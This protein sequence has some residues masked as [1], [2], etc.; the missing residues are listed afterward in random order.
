MRIASFDIGTRNMAYCVLEFIP[1]QPQYPIKVI[2]WNVLD[3]KYNN[4]ELKLCVE[5]TNQLDSYLNVFK[6]VDRLVIER[7]PDKRMMRISGIL[8]GYFATRFQVDHIGMLKKVDFFNA[9]NKFK[10]YTGPYV[11]KPGSLNGK[12]NYKNR[13][14]YATLLCRNMI[15]QFCSDRIDF[16]KK[17]TKNDDLSDCFLQGFTYIYN[18]FP[19]LKPTFSGCYTSQPVQKEEKRI[20][21]RKP[22]NKQVESEKY[23]LSNFKYLLNE[24]LEIQYALNSESIL[25]D[26]KIVDITE[27]LTRELPNDKILSSLS[28]Q[29]YNDDITKIQHLIKDKFIKHQYTVT[30]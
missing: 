14:I 4:N 13:K 9:A 28:Q 19:H 3:L 29:F 15:N 11:K 20:V 30:I 12:K 7:Q 26:S 17:H 6:T 27:L 8:E 18:C 1:N 2:D 10:C 22:T 16:F 21:S 25:G 24:W 5:L 23:T